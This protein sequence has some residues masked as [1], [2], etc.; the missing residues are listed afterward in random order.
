MAHSNR[1][2]L[3]DSR[4][5]K[6]KH[7]ARKAAKAARCRS[8]FDL[9]ARLRELK[10][11]EEA[12]TNKTMQQK[13]EHVVVNKRTWSKKQSAQRRRINALDRLKAQYDAFKFSK[14]K[15]EAEIHMHSK[16]EREISTLKHRIG[17]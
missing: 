11:D 4:G 12:R 15:T 7:Q 2:K 3:R 14:E 6:T 1:K 5:G 8:T 10:A 16:M 17:V 13:T 9:D